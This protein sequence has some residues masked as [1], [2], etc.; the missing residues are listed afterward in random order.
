MTQNFFRRGEF[1]FRHLDNLRRQAY[2]VPNE[3]GIY[4][5]Y[6]WRKDKWELVYYGKAGM[7]KDGRLSRQGIY[8]R[9]NN[10][11]HDVSRQ[12][13]FRTKMHEEQVD[14]LKIKWFV[15]YDSRNKINPN[16]IEAEFYKL[17]PSAKWNMKRGRP[18]KKV[19]IAYH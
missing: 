1:Y 10:T 3:P 2:A 5:I 11:H 14:V 19:A 18:S 4:L 16:D 8:D 9:I 6:A 12:T 17:A 15:T 13:Y 7:T